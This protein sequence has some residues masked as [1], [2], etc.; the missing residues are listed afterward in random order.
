MEIVC[1]V[2]LRKIGE[3]DEKVTLLELKTSAVTATAFVFFRL[4][5]HNEVTGLCEKG[6]SRFIN[7]GY[8]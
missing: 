6:S 2:H 1:H 5:D 8:L 4:T 7:H 3:F